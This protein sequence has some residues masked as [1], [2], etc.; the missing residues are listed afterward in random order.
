MSF[1]CYIMPAMRW[2]FWTE[3][4]NAWNRGVT[5]FKH[6]IN[7][8]Q[9]WQGTGGQMVVKFKQNCRFI[10]SSYIWR[11]VFCHHLPLTSL[12]WSRKSMTCG[13]DS[14]TKVPPKFQTCHLLLSRLKKDGFGNRPSQLP[15]SPV[16]LYLA[17]GTIVFRVSIVPFPQLC[18]PYC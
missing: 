11:T 15:W 14:S 18:F 4:K 12:V 2:Q 8:L 9:H 10:G 17:V 3:Q 6:T 7:C 1:R 16:S 13:S 5:S